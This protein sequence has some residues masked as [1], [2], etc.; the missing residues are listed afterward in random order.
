[1]DGLIPEIK[2]TIAGWQDELI[3]IRH[4]FRV[5]LLGQPKVKPDHEQLAKNDKLYLVSTIGSVILS[6]SLFGLAIFGSFT[7]GRQ[8][9]QNHGISHEVA[10]FIPVVLEVMVAVCVLV[11]F[12]NALVGLTSS[13]WVRLT[14]V[15]SSAISVTFNVLHILENAKLNNEMVTW[16]DWEVLLL[17]AVFPIAVII[18]SEI[19]S[20]QIRSYVAR[21]GNILLS[22]TLKAELAKLIDQSTA[23]KAEHALVL[24][25]IQTAKTELDQIG[26]QAKANTYNLT[27]LRIAALLGKMG[28]TTTG[29][30]IG[31]VLDLSKAHANRT[32]SEVLAK[33]EDLL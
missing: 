12:S 15:S 3:S 4:D 28:K 24:E 26:E 16:T 31:E 18:T 33:I 6:V 32:K 7:A 13:F 10:P 20:V 8:F 2:K 25:Q 22:S 17:G 19:A 14:L 1:M 29:T 11:M 23:A 9:A 27:Q 21:H 5:W 30:A